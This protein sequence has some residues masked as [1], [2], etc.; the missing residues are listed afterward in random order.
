VAPRMVAEFD[1]HTSVTDVRSLPDHGEPFEF[2]RRILSEFGTVRRAAMENRG[3]VEALL[4][5]RQLLPDTSWVPASTIMTPLRMIKDEE[6][7]CR[8]AARHRTW[9]TRCWLPCCRS[10]K[11]DERT[12]RGARGECPDG[13]PRL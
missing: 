4:N 12:G 10:S 3:W 11:W 1:L 2:M 7:D 13:T 6:R 5:L 8:D 9:L